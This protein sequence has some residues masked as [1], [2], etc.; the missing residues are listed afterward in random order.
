MASKIWARSCWLGL[1]HHE[2]HARA[3]LDVARRKQLAFQKI[4]DDGRFGA[5]EAA[6]IA[7]AV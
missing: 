1:P 6:G 4:H 3:V 5:V 2:E 7:A